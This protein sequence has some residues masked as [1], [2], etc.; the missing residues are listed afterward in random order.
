LPLTSAATVEMVVPFWIRVTAAPLP[1]DAGVM[2]P[3]T[4]YV[5]PDTGA[6]STS[7]MVRL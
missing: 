1:S 7:T 6:A 2:E 4:V 3:E 5:G